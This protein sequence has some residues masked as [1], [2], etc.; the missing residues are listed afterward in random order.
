MHLC[1]REKTELSRAFPERIGICRNAELIKFKQADD[2]IIQSIC[3][4]S[5][6]QL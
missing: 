3:L 2:K 1:Y 6:K 4:L 5:Y